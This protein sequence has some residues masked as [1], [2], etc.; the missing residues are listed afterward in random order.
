MPWH[1]Q[2]SGKIDQPRKLMRPWVVRAARLSTLVCAMVSMGWLAYV[3]M[4]HVALRNSGLCSPEEL[5]LILW[6]ELVSGPALVVTAA[7]I[8]ALA[9]LLLRRIHAVRS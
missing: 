5:S 3:L 1:N 4:L 2:P 9:W 6:N 7:L 8:S